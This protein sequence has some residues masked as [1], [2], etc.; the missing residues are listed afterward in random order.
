MVR[1]LASIT[2]YILANAVG[3]LAA[4]ILLSDFRIDGYGFVVSLLF[5]TVVGVVLGPF[6]LKLSVKYMPALRG[7]IA[8][9][10]TFV[11]LLLTSIFTNGLTIAGWQTWVVA[12]LVVWLFV[13]L[14]GILL[15]MVLFKEVLARKSGE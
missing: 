1:F 6:I 10:T 5:F 8:L 14:A 4:M 11:G 3:L 12:P 2:L 7:G 15:P 13:L 9:V